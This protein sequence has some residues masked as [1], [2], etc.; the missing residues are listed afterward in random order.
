[1]KRRYQIER[2]RAVQSIRRLA[3]E[4]NP[5]IEMILPLRTALHNHRGT[6]PPRC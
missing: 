3:A 6:K 5:N 1:M 4:E 2:H